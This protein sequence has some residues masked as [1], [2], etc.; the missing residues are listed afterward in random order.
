MTDKVN[1]RLLGFVVSSAYRFDVLYCLRKTSKMPTQI[2]KE[3]SQ[4]NTQTSTT[5]TELK[6]AALI[7]CKNESK[8]KGRE[9]EITND[10][11]EIIR[12]MIENKLKRL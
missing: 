8:T 7:K 3:L 6:K 1:Y 4:S 10:G 5:L 2:S 11:K 9:Y 12:L